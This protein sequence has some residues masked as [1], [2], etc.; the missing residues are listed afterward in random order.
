MTV[1]QSS[2]DKGGIESHDLALQPGTKLW[3]SLF[4]NV[5]KPQD[6]FPTLRAHSHLAMM[7]AARVVSTSQLIVA[8]NMALARKSNNHAW[9]TVMGASP[10][11]HVEHVLR[12]YAFGEDSIPQDEAKVL[13]LAV[14]GTLNDFQA[15]LKEVGFKDPQPIPPFFSKQKTPEEIANIYRWYKI[16]IDEVAMSSLEQAVLTRISTKF[17]L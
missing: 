1:V 17:Y 16:T 12:D 5:S 9:E 6:L 10:S 2:F 15:Q 4:Y 11:T 7:D 14:G 3:L 8:A 13:V